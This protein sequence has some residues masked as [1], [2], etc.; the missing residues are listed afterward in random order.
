MHNK[1]KIFLWTYSDACNNYIKYLTHDFLIVYIIFL[2]KISLQN[3][4]NIVILKISK[5][6]RLSF[7]DSQT[8]KFTL[9]S[10]RYFN[11]KFI[12][13]HWLHYSKILSDIWNIL[14]IFYW[15]LVIIFIVW[16]NIF[17]ETFQSIDTHT[18]SVNI[19]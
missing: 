11:A 1:F 17:I 4:I 16:S 12:N 15:I 8:Y 10:Y 3:Y 6:A 13:S 19:F 18:Y 5:L 7:Y 2:L 14:F 9:N